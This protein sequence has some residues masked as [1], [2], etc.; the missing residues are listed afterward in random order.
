MNSIIFGRTAALLA[1]AL[2]LASPA[3]CRAQATKPA[4]APPSLAL[5]SP[6]LWTDAE[7]AACVT[8]WG[9]AGRMMVSF[10]PPRAA[11]TP[12]ASLWFHGF[13]RILRTAPPAEAAVWNAWVDAKF[14]RDRWEAG[15]L[16]GAPSL[17]PEPALP[18][19]IPA[20][21]LAAVGDPP[22]LAAA[23]VPKRYTIN[24]GD[25][26]PL[27]YVA[28]IVLP[29]RYPFYRF[30]EGVISGGEALKAM[31]TGG[32]DG[33]MR[34]AGL[35]PF[36]AHV[37]GTVSRLEGGFDAVNTYDTGY[38]SVGF[39]QFITAAGGD[40]SLTA[41]LAAEKAA[42]PTEFETDFHR[43]GIDVTPEG[44]Y[45]AVD[46]ATGAELRGTDAVQDTI[47]DP[48]LV[49]VFQAAGQRSISFRIAQL[50][51]AK[52][53]YY[54]AD[55][56]IL[57][58]PPGGTPLTGRVGDVLRSE[59]GM[60]TAFDRKVNTGHVAPEVAAA[61]QSVMAAH[62][63]TTLSDVAPYER[64]VVAALKY[65]ADFLAD[66]TLTQP[67]SPPVAPEGR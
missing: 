54:P 12:E 16:A 49:A 27:T 18:G 61:V 15:Q 51:T 45:T 5:P 46:P 30:A 42:Q 48:R 8:F 20:S 26:L 35:T 65:R 66:T 21:L 24:L 7:R 14:A 67:P 37:I 39:I 19:V 44:I 4:V 59:A 11:L 31:P 34:A 29:P 40:G 10:A 56:P 60:A 50:L 52:R 3:G 63:L 2:C 17:V 28:P 57:V 33:L 25:G 23:V 53:V 22:P 32:L 41:V 13:N 47:R 58:T 55:D 62:H 43:R 36:E 6:P 1:T 9:D 38:V 64:E